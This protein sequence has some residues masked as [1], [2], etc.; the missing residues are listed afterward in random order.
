M[1]TVGGTS[2]KNPFKV[3]YEVTDYIS[4]GGFSN[5]F[6]MPDYQ[7]LSVYTGHNLWQYPWVFPKSV[8]FL[9]WSL[10]FEKRYVVRNWVKRLTCINYQVRYTK[11][12]STNE[13]LSTGRISHHWCTL[14]DVWSIYFCMVYL[15]RLIPTRWLFIQSSDSLSLFATGRCCGGLSESSVAS[16]SKDVFQH[17][18]TGLPRHS[19]SLRQLLGGHRQGTHPLGV[20]YFGKKIVSHRVNLQKYILL[21]P[22]VLP[23][24]IGEDLRF[25]LSNLQYTLRRRQRINSRLFSSPTIFFFLSQIYK[26]V[27]NYLWE[28]LFTF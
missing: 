16:P 14:N 2:F 19:R 15:D 23:Q 9:K 4:G 3:T 11:V 5:V 10:E 17:Q 25:L 8:L 27:F 26:K 18:W 28:I 12:L 1:T 24:Q 22:H 13:V 20:W 6:K 21:I 7:V